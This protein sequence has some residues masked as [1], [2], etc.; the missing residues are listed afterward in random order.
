VMT[1]LP[2]YTNYLGGGTAVLYYKTK[3]D[4]NIIHACER[5]PDHIN[6]L[7]SNLHE[8]M[9][10]S[11][12]MGVLVAYNIIAFIFGMILF[13][14]LCLN[15][16]NE[17]RGRYFKE[18]R[19]LLHAFHFIPYIICVLYICQYSQMDVDGG[20]K[21]ANVMLYSNSILNNNCFNGHEYH[22]VFSQLRDDVIS[23][24]A[25]FTRTTRIMGVVSYIMFVVLLLIKG[26]RGYYKPEAEAI[27]ADVLDKRFIL[28]QRPIEP[29]IEISVNMMMV[30]D[31]YEE[32]EVI[33]PPVLPPENNE[34][35]GGRRMRRRIFE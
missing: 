14:F 5:V 11:G 31:G 1:K 33:P 10:T 2:E 8:F 23:L 29:E 12:L 19:C 27:E 20:Q 24:K 22:G 28:I 6:Y 15:K 34:S 3:I 21:A 25:Y 9:F 4:L 18:Q 17:E 35:S 26:L 32:D 16:E 30:Y 13:T 7:K